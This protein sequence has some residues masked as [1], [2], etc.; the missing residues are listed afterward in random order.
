MRTTA[1]QVGRWIL[2]AAVAAI[3]ALALSG[4]QDGAAAGDSST[5]T[6]AVAALPR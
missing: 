2:A 1:E 3:V 4:A 6:G 5:R